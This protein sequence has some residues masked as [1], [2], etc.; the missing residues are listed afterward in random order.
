M[1]CKHQKWVRFLHEAPYGFAHRNGQ[2]FLKR[3]LMQKFKRLDLQL[4]AEGGD[5]AGTGTSATGEAGA[6]TTGVSVGVPDQQQS[7][8]ELG[9]PQKLI[10]RQKQRAQKRGKPSSAA[11]ATVENSA[12]APQVQPAQAQTETAPTTEAQKRLTFEEI[13]KDPEYNKEMQKIVQSRLKES[14][15][16]KETL[17][18][19]API[20]NSIGRIYDIDTSDLSNL[21]FDALSRAVGS[22]DPAIEAK[23]IELGIPKEQA[24]AIVEAERI[25]SEQRQAQEKS[26]EQQKIQ[27]HL[28]GI[29]SQVPELQKEFPSFDLETE[30]Q[31]PDFA[32]MTA[33]GVN[34]PLRTAY[35]AVHEREIR[36]AEKAQ[37]AQMAQQAIT[38][39][40]RSKQMRPQETGAN[41]QQASVSTLDM[42]S[43]EYRSYI[44]EQMRLA[45]RQGKRLYPDGSIR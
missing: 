44:K 28:E 5:G 29:Y 31:N 12:S 39:S 11:P 35:F 6:G 25:I 37:A 42:S 15:S 10:D 36:E 40:I 43:P 34:V 9:V 17:D 33:P 8:A 13:L 26:F 18:K 32:R 16:A 38:Q 3:H 45:E 24:R 27:A 14:K 19:I 1:L 2:I 22:D 20:L 4:F 30:L 41:T 23:S 21:D 7:L